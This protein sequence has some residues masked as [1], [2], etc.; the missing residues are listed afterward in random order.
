MEIDLFE[1]DEEEEEDWNWY[2]DIDQSEDRSGKESENED[3]HNMSRAD[4]EEELSALRS[5][6]SY[7]EQ[8]DADD[9]V[10][11]VAAIIEPIK[12]RIQTILD[13]IEFL[14]NNNQY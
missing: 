12:T 2:D 6:Q 14:E 11:E 3:V 13:R 1:F 10:E 8:F 9:E 7:F 4:L 5:R